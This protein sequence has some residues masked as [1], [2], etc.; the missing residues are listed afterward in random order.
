MYKGVQSRR[1][2]ERIG[3][4]VGGK[5]NIL[6]DGRH[7]IALNR[8]VTAD[9]LWSAAKLNQSPSRVRTS[10]NNQVLEENA[11][12]LRAMFQKFSSDGKRWERLFPGWIATL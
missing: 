1:A 7:L 3:M 10:D 6:R 12:S 9:R 11:P 4:A 8:N 2:K 5:N